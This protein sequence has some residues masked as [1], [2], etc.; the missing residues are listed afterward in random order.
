MGEPHDASQLPDEERRHRRGLKFRRREDY[1]VELL[2][3]AQGTLSDIPRIDRILVELGRFYNPYRNGPIV[4]LATRRAV[5]E[6]LGRGDEPTA[7]ALLEQCLV[8]Y[9]SSDPPEPATE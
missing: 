6:A 7:R 2:R 5:L 3:E 9:A 1:A 8:A 4:D